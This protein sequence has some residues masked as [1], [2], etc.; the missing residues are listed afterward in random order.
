MWHQYEYKIAKKL[1]E[2]DFECYLNQI[3]SKIK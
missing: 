2:P 1:V 3:L